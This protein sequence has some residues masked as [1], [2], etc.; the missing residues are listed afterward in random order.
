MAKKI[1]ILGSGQVGKTL[2]NAFLEVGY[3]VKIGSRSPKKLDSWLK[4]TGGKARSGTYVDVASFGEIIVLATLGQA[5]EEV[6][7]LAGSKNFAGK[8]V[9]DAMNPLDFSKG[10]IPSLLPAYNTLSLGEFVQRKL[11]NSKVVKCFNTVPNT[12]MFRPKFAG[13]QMLICGNNQTAKEEVTAILRQFGWSGA[14]DVGG[15][16]DVRWLESLALL[17]MKAARTTQA[18]DS[19]FMLVRE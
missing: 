4:E 15:I 7:N 9:I 1:G 2:G 17:W 19:I 11:P 13:A 6:I 8:L 14:I 16:E 3:E 12:Q 5:A 18:W 10:M